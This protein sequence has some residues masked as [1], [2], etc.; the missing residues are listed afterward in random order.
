M[1][2]PTGERKSLALINAKIDGSLTNM[3]AQV[4]RSPSS[5]LMTQIEKLEAATKKIPEKIIIMCDASGSFSDDLPVAEKQIKSLR[6]QIGV[7]DCP[8][9]FFADAGEHI[10]VWDGVQPMT[11]VFL[12]GRGNRH[13]GG[14]QALFSYFKQ[15]GINLNARNSESKPIVVY[16]LTD[17]HADGT[18]DGFEI[19]ANV[20][21][22]FRGSKTNDN[23]REMMMRL[24]KANVVLH[25]YTPEKNDTN[26]EGDPILFL[27]FVWQML[28]KLTGG[29]WHKLGSMPEAVAIIQAQ[30]LEQLAKADEL[31]KLTA[32]KEEAAVIAL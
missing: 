30:T 13:E 9:V 3:K 10:E 16:M 15:S 6:T 19:N 14:V 24:K 31:L 28:A 8:V 22:D 17:E 7:D 4:L 5:K 25:A 23:L 18:L 12:E 11:D 2:S 27:G 21:N 1:T 32:P 20:K 29:D 26:Y